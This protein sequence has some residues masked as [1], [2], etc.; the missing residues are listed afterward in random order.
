MVQDLKFEQRIATALKKHGV[1]AEPK[2]LFG[3]VAFMV[4]GHM[5]VRITYKDDLMARFDAN[6]HA[7]VS[8]WRGARPMTFGKGGIKGFLFGKVD[9]VESDAAL[10]KWVR[11][12]LGC[13]STLP[14]KP[15]KKATAR[16]N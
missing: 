11:L 8:Q 2:N 14:A 3:G 9:A 1:R 13:V 10:T 15:K 16:K 7:K 12:S 4:F 6:W 5:G